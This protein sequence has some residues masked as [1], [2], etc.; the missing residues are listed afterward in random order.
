M[1]SKQSHLVIN[2]LL[3][4]NIGDDLTEKC[5]SQHSL[6]NDLKGL[7]LKSKRGRPKKFI[8]GKE[9]KAFKIPKRRRKGSKFGLP[10]LQF[11][12]QMDKLDEAKAILD[13]GIQMGLIPIKMRKNHYPSL[14]NSFCC[15]CGITITILN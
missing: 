9:N 5:N 6:V 2:S 15:E 1:N 14:E 4:D 7:R 10:I 11:T 12:Q 3:E 13:T 8:Q